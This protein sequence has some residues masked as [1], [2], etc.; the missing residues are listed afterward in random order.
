MAVSLRRWMT[1][2]HLSARLAGLFAA[3]RG[4]LRDW[5]ATAFID[6]RDLPEIG[7]ARAIVAYQPNRRR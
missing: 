1:R 5:P 4:R 3:A 7:L 6:D 2:S